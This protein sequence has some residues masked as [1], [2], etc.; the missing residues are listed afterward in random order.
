LDSSLG[1]R[2]ACV[3]LKTQKRPHELTVRAPFI[4]LSLVPVPG[5]A[6][7]LSAKNCTRNSREMVGLAASWNSQLSV[8]SCQSVFHDAKLRTDG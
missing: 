6:T 8:V 7:L 3:W 1:S 2:L 5:S 4:T